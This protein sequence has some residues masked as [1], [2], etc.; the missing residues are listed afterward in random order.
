MRVS[1]Q[2]S[3]ISPAFHGCTSALVRGPAPLGPGA[4]F[5][6]RNNVKKD[7]VAAVVVFAICI[8]AY[9]FLSAFKLKKGKILIKACSLVVFLNGSVCR[10]YNIS[11]KLRKMHLVPEMLYNI[12][13][14]EAGKNIAW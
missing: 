3:G 5:G 10:R 2:T 1:E 11:H 14:R 12:L 13:R 4:P 6:N 9:K 8:F 7:N